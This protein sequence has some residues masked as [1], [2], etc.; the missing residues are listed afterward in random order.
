M[1]E[2]R[3]P[4]FGTSGD[5]VEILE[6]LVNVGDAVTVGQNVIEVASDKVD[7]SIESEVAGTV[8]AVHCAVG[9]DVE[10]GAVVVTVD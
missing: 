1:S 5:T 8:T 7:V 3:V 4:K 10:M 2:V 6:I 9:D